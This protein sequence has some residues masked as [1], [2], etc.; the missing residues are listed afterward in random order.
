[1]ARTGPIKRRNTILAFEGSGRTE[2]SFLLQQNGDALI[3]QRRNADNEGELTPAR[4]FEDYENWTK[5]RPMLTQHDQPAALNLFSER[6]GNVV[7]NQLGSSTDLTIP[8]RYLVLH[9]AF[10]SLPWRQYHPTWAYWED[11]CI[12]IIGFIP[13]GFFSLLTSRPR[14]R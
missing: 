11:A 4:V 2:A 14:A 6:R 12:N 8:V 5:N 13:L 3:V 9:S 1:L 10:L 7:H